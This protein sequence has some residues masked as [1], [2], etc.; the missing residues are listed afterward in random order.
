[1]IVDSSLNHVDV[2]VMEN[3]V[4][5]WRL[6]CFYGYLQRSRRKDSWKF[7]HYLASKFSLP[8]CILEYF[9]DLLYASDKIGKNP[10]PQALLTDLDKRL[11]I[12]LCWRLI[13]LGRL[14]LGEKQRRG[15]RTPYSTSF[16]YASYLSSY[17]VFRSRSYKS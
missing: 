14:H 2:Q 3:N 17:N 15:Q 4:T 10:H 1:M 12:V 9:N 13:Y 6:M 8:W 16:L 11:K 5:S 7:I